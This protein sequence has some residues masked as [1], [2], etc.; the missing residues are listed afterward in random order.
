MAFWISG[1][2]AWDEPLQR[3]H[4]AHAHR[5]VNVGLMGA[6]ERGRREL[7]GLPRVGAVPIEQRAVANVFAPK[8]QSLDGGE[9]EAA[10]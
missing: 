2:P 8:A 6:G 9:P 10:V 4:P 7:G 5:R 3:V 1:K